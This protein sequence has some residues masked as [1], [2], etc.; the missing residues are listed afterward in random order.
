MHIV[1]KGLSLPTGRLSRTVLIRTN[2]EDFRMKFP[3]AIIERKVKNFKTVNKTK[4]PEITKIFRTSTLD[5]S[6]A[7]CLQ[8]KRPSNPS[9]RPKNF[10][11]LFS[12]V[13]EVVTC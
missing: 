9:F 5:T 2:K 1:F 8:V 6:L 11:G 3:V 13:S 4:W 7:S 12:R 10:L